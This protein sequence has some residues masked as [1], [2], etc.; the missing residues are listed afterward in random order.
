MCGAA[1]NIARLSF[2]S[3]NTTNLSFPFDIGKTKLV[4][5]IVLFQLQEIKE[6]EI[7]SIKRAQ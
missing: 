7:E 3:E 1:G 2:V 5:T 6:R 4:C